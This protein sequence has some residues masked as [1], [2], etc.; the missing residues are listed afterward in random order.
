M[1]KIGFIVE[2]DSEKILIE[3]DMFQQWCGKNGI[4]I[5]DPVINAEG[6]GNLL[7]EFM[8]NHIRRLSANGKPDKIVVLTDLETSG[9]VHVARKRILTG[10][11]SKKIDFVFISIKAVE[12]WF[13]SD[14]KAMSA[15]LESRF[16]EDLPEK[17]QGMPWDRL[18]EIADKRGKRGP[19][20][21]PM[22]AKKILSLG[23]SIE[24]AA[25]HPHCPSV[26]EFYDTLTGWG[27]PVL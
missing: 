1:V 13:L 6:G 3:S 10:K 4:T 8:A 19:G 21:K 17:T 26:K 16:H 20:S 25:R 18:K 22:F 15:W 12:A 7:P 5:V 24:N 2:G 9:T 14:D 11:S 27:N 23:F